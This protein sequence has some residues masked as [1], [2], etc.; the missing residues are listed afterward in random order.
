MPSLLV[1]HLVG[2]CN[3]GVLG[4]DNVS[5]YGHDN[6]NHGYDRTDHNEVREILE[7]GRGSNL[8]NQPP[9]NW[10]LSNLLCKIS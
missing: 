7:G 2:S 5:V 4:D 6:L 10:S 8:V 1:I 3:N 9:S